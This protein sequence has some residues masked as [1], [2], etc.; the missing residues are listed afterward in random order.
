[1]GNAVHEMLIYLTSQAVT[2]ART[3]PFT[4]SDTAAVVVYGNGSADSSLYQL[5]AV[6]NSLCYRNLDQRLSVKTGDLY[7]FICCNNNTF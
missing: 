1:M 2:A 6:M 7:S 4:F 5:L 3:S